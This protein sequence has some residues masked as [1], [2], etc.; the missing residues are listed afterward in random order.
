[1]HGHVRGSL[2]AQF[3][4][5]TVR[6]HDLHHDPA[7]DDDVFVDLAGED[8][9]GMKGLEVGSGG[10]RDRMDRVLQ[11]KLGDVGRDA[12]LADERVPEIGRAHV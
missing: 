8:E 9:H 10:D 2:D 12:L 3:D 11:G 7:V 4:E 5:V 1:M 6:A